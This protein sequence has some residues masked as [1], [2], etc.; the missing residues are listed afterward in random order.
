MEASGC[1][2]FMNKTHKMFTERWTDALELA[3]K[4]FCENHGDSDEADKRFA[5]YI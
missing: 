3:Y 2:D 1:Y 4:K 5:G